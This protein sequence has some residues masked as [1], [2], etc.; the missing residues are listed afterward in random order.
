MAFK[1]SKRFLT[2]ARPA[3][4]RYQK[5]LAEAQHRDVNE[6]DTSVIVSDFLSDVL[7]Y[8]KYQEVTTEY[9]VR[10]TYCDLAIT[11]DGRLCYLIEVK[12]I[13]ADL[14]EN[15]V[16]QAVDYG[17]KEGCEWVILTNGAVW[18]AYRIRFEKP[19]DY[20]L[21]FSVD[22]LAEGAAP[23]DLLPYLSLIA[24]ESSGGKEIDRFWR[25]KQATSRFVIAQ[26]LLQE[27]PLRLLRRELRKL[28]PDVRI[29]CDQLAALLRAELL[30]RDALE[31][32]KAE[33]AA[34]LLRRAARRRARQTPSE[35]VVPPGAAPTLPR[36]VS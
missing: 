36:A 20:D 27:R 30:K 15:H 29:S 4:R 21:T 8:D 31:G 18:H 32:E 22:L 28:S 12:P 2:R 3:L 11:C 7:G 33:A 17:A 26:I 16:R 6:S 35:K 14:R 23:A 5:V 13:G 19:V 10:S 24:K 25:Q 9:A 34:A 1:V